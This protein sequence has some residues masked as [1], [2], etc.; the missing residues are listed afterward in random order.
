MANTSY[1][2]TVCRAG[3]T[4][5]GGS[6]WSFR[7][8]IVIIQNNS[9]I[10]VSEWNNQTATGNTTYAMWEIKGMSA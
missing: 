8:L 10:T 6:G 7:E 9:T 1:T 3:G 4:D 5:G 2:A